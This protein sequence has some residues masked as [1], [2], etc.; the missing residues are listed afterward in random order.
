MHS[1]PT[2]LPIVLASTCLVVSLSAP[3]VPPAGPAPTKAATVGGEAL[4]VAERKL[5]KENLESLA[6]FRATEKK[7][8]E[9]VYVFALKF[10]QAVNLEGLKPVANI[11]LEPA[12]PYMRKVAV[13]NFA[14][15]WALDKAT[16]PAS[17]SAVSVAVPVGA[18][19]RGPEIGR[20][21]AV[22][23]QLGGL[24]EATFENLSAILRKGADR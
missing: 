16:T 23:V 7:S 17:T 22:M 13:L 2:R 15:E 9:E 4:S 10:K 1:F 21:V 11:R 14:S 18:T 3:A 6:V 24:P 5:T 19:I 12:P 20:R 8:G